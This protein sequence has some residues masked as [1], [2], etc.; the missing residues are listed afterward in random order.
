MSGALYFAFESP[1][2]YLGFRVKQNIAPGAQIV[3]AGSWSSHDAIRENLR[4]PRTHR[5]AHAALRGAVICRVGTLS[6]TQRF[7]D[8]GRQQAAHQLRTVRKT[9]VEDGGPARPFL[10]DRVE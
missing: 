1:R 2:P 6:R 9:V 8:C 5:R 10:A 3:A 7:R 4:R